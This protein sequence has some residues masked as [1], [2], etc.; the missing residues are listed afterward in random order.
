MDDMPN[1]PHP[2]HYEDE[3]LAALAKAIGHPVRLRI[4]RL[5]LATPGCMAPVPS[6]V[7]D[8]G[9]TAPVIV[10]NVAVR[11]SNIRSIVIGVVAYVWANAASTASTSRSPAG[12]RHRRYSGLRRMV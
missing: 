10:G 3:A 11:R 4:L 1:M 9:D 5:L 2:T 7:T 8:A 12:C 6:S